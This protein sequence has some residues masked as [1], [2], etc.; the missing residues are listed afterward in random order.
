MQGVTYQLKQWTI[1]AGIYRASDFV[2][3]VFSLSASLIAEINMSM[4]EFSTT[5]YITF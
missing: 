2:F 5:G 4:S 3:F 1:K